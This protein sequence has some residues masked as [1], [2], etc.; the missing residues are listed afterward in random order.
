MTL[1]DITLVAAFDAPHYLEWRTSMGVWNKNCPQLFDM[2]WALIADDD[3]YETVVSDWR[4]SGAR[5]ERVTSPKEWPQR[6]RMLSVF[7]RQAP[8]LVETSHFLKLD[9]DCVCAAPQKL[10]PDPAWFEGDPV[11]IS[12]GWNYSKPA[13]VIETLDN[14]WD[15]M[16]DLAKDCPRL[17]LP[18][19][20]TWSRIVH[21]RIISFL[22]IGCTSW[23]RWLAGIVGERLPFP[24]QDSVCWFAAERT[25]AFYRK[26]RFSKLGWRHVGSGGER[27]KRAVEEALK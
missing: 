11:F 17:D 18:Y 27:L 13:N 12:S 9:T 4:H 6:E 1:R 26:V 3:I 24:S 25:K 7:V 5:I 15:T 10:F 21:K 23:H 22:Y 8:F 14:W 2:P 20:P 16:P 19:D